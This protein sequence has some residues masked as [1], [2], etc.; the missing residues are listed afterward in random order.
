MKNRYV[1]TDIHGCA[2]T[3]EALLNKIGLTKEDE[4][5]IL[6]DYVDR[7]PGGKQSIDI[8]MGLE[9]EGYS[10]HSLVGNHDLMLWI[11]M[12]KLNPSYEERYSET[13]IS[14]GVENATHIP[15]KYGDWITNLPYYIELDQYI[16]VHGGVNFKL[17]DPL[18]VQ[19]DLLVARG[20]YD[21]IN[22]EWLGDRIIIHGHTPVPQKQLEE[23]VDNQLTNQY[24]DLD[25]G[26]VFDNPGFR[27]LVCLNLKDM[28]L[29]YQKNIDGYHKRVFNL[30][31]V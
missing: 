10:V 22:Y 1:I 23:M 8:V 4:L 27:H 24:I 15:K 13:A 18:S 19:A 25:N 12:E 29:T 2:N 14:F 16:L 30:Y 26:C 5:Y 28:S 9:D 3:F 31:K 20:W 7:G 17:E 11:A 21:E 6:G